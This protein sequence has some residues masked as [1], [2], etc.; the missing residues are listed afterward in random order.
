M[1][2]KRQNAQTVDLDPPLCVKFSCRA[3]A[4]LQKS[5]LIGEN[6]SRCWAFR[7][8]ANK[9]YSD[10]GEIFYNSIMDTENLGVNFHGSHIG[11]MQ[12]L[13][14]RKDA[15]YRWRPVPYSRGTGQEAGRLCAL[16]EENSGFICVDRNGVYCE[17]AI[18]PTEIGTM[19]YDGETAEKMYVELR[20]IFRRQAVKA[21]NGAW[22]CPGAYEHRERYRFCTIDI[23][24]PPECDLSVE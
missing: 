1:F 13:I 18:F 22:I 15:E 6:I 9:A 17:N 14:F 5:A 23:K 10:S 8:F 4:R 7:H 16:S 24:S 20:R 11:N 19:Y 2:E 12:I 21:V 3:S